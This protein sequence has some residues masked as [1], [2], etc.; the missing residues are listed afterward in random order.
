MI[1]YLRHLDMRTWPKNEKTELAFASVVQLFHLQK[2]T[3]EGVE[4]QI[5]YWRP[6]DPNACEGFIG[7]AK[8]MQKNL[9]A[10]V[11]KIH[12]AIQTL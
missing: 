9:T 12:D 5:E 4:A 6:R 10:T 11:Q 2:Q 1:D 8:D 7:V 3:L